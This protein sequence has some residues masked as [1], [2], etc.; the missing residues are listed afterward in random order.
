MGRVFDRP[1]HTGILG[2]L[3][4]CLLLF[5]GSG[6]AEEDEAA[7]AMESSERLSGGRDWISGRF[8]AGIDAIRA[9]GSSDLNLDQTLRLNIDPPDH[10]RLHLRGLYWFHQ[11]LDSDERSTSSLRDIN[12]ASSSDVRARIL[13]SYLQVDD[14]WGKSTLRIGRQRVEEGAAWNRFDGVYFNKQA[15]QW[16]WYVFGGMR[17]SIYRDAHNDLVAGGG[18]SFRPDARTRISLDFYYGEDNRRSSENITPGLSA[19]LLGYNFPRPVKQNISDTYTSFSLWRNLSENH[20]VYGRLTLHDGDLD[21]LLLNLTG[22]WPGAD[23]SYDVAYR[24]RFRT[25]ADRVADISPFYRVM[26]AYEEFDDLLLALHK[27][28]S[29]RFN[30]SLEAQ[31][32]DTRQGDWPQYNRDYKRYAAILDIDPLFK[33]ARGS[34]ALEKWDVSNGES[35]WTLTGEITRRWP[36]ERIEA[37]LGADYARYE[38]RITVY[39][40]PLGQLDKFLVVFA[41]GYY[42]GYNPIIFLFDQYAVTMHEDIYSIYGKMKWDFRENQNISLGITYEM[43]DGPDSPYWRVQAGYS[44]RF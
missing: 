14:L 7:A 11:D 2:G 38:D 5:A 40:R 9:S 35:T 8:D 15:G 12:D 17:A 25:A 44:I 22:Y 10:P 33:D 13:I 41:P 6:I 26:G 21:E 39:N 36:K 3:L 37:T 30:L 28:L 43:D 16:Q 19:R 20:N 23:L 4:V 31:F 24:G 32:R 1:K 34:L 29:E 42:A 27:P 18:I